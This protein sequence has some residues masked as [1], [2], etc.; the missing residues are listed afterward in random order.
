MADNKRLW[1]PPQMIWSAIVGIALWTAIG[2]SWFGTGFNWTTQGSAL[3]LSTNAVM[4]SMAAIC[5]AQAR[6]ASDPEATLEQLAALDNWKQRNF[7]EEAKWSNMPGSDSSE[8][9]V[10]ELCATKLRAT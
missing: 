9:G 5:V 10:A 2:F 1:S 3:K 8:S 7:I 4:E 6:G